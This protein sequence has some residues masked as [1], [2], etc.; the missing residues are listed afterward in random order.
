MVLLSERI[1]AAVREP[2]ASPP[3]WAVSVVA[4]VAVAIA[5]FLSARLSL[6]LLEKPDG[7]AAFW[8]AA[9][10]ASGTLIVVGSVTRWRVIGGVMAA[11]ILANLLGDRNIWSSI[12]FAVANASEAAI[13]AGLIER[14]YGSQFELNTLRRVMGL[15]AATI[16]GTAISGIVGTIGFVWFHG[17]A[18][19]SIPTIWFHW[20]ASDGLGTLTVAPLVI[21]LASLMRNVPS[22]REAVESALALAVLCV[23]C[24]FLVFLPNM[25]WTLELAIIALCPLFVWIAARL[26]PGIASAATFICAI[27]IVATTTFAIGIFGD[28]RLSFDQRIQSAQASILAISFGALVLTALFSERRLQGFA[29]LDREARLQE[30]LRAGGVIAFEWDIRADQVR[31]SQNALPILGLG[32]KDVVSASDMLGHVHPDDRSHVMACVRGVNPDKPSYSMTFRYRRADVDSDGWLE[33]VATAQFDSDRLPVRIR[34]LTTDITERKRFE[35][36]ILRAQKQAERAD[37]TKSIFLAAASHDLRQPLQT[38]RLLHGELRQQHPDG[39]GQKI[40]AGMGRSID[41]MSSMLS[42]LLDI[43]RLETGTLRPSKSDFAVNE[44]FDS[45]ASDLLLPLEEKGLQWRVVQ[46]DLVVRSDKRMLEEMIRNLLSNAIRYTDRGKILLGCRRAGD[47]IRIEVWDTGIGIPGDQLPHIFEEYYCDAERGG[48]GLGLAIVRRLGEILGHRVD[49]RSTP[50]KGTGFSIEVPLGRACVGAS[51]SVPT[52]DFDGE[53]FRGTVLVIEDETSV[54]SAVNRILTARGIGV[55]EAATLSD[56]A[57]AL[58]KQKDLRPDLVL[59]DY[60]LPGPMN[61]VESIK[62]LRAALAWNLPAIVMT[63]DTRSKTME[64]IASY[65]LSVLIKPF[66]SDELIQLMNRLY[67]SSESHG[68]D[69]HLRSTNV[70]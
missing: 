4:T 19:A 56:A 11:T 15:F 28:S 44:I 67:R 3:R 51:E 13:V 8:P 69:R 26:P 14:S 58:M 34:G 68:S 47:K 60:N 61:G 9:G 62:S 57:A 33:Q 1:W 42:S 70:Q 32:S 63:G 48:F 64:A 30:A 23:L 66:S 6:A 45:A 16:A 22:T 24:A 41:T 27:T 43:N 40:I 20:F 31:Y 53:S 2:E 52:S 38:L 5:Y 7:V 18:T 46:S 59:C 25:P 39:D 50:G 55:I 37:R 65:G 17:D 36:E 49:V 54:R 29:L 21:G 10:V 35:E 12:L